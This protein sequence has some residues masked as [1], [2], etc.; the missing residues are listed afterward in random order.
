MKGLSRHLR[1]RLAEGV[2]LRYELASPVARVLALAVDGCAVSAI[3][4][5]LYGLLHPV[6]T[7]RPDWGTAML[8]IGYF[9]VS[10]FYAILLEW[11][12]GGRTLGKRL[13]GL[14]VLDLE[15]RPLRFDQA[16][17]RNLLKLIDRLPL[18]YGLGGIAAVLSPRWQRLGD[19]A[20]GTVV[21]RQRRSALPDWSLVAPE[22]FNSLRSQHRLA[23]RLRQRCSASEAELGLELLQ[24]RAKL[25]D[26]PRLKLFAALAA[27]YRAHAGVLPEALEG[28]SD[29]QWVRAVVD[30]L[31]QAA[32]EER[33]GGNGRRAAAIAQQTPAGV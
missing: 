8:L 6:L 16:L 13:L 21:V 4:G 24:R 32:Q 14:R 19:L 20:A 15:G 18:F 3:L 10:T 5:T 27:R 33:S 29:E 25:E 9:T 1:L 11:L 30:V 23:G 7:A 31:Y 26:G 17:L 2:D 28:L 12:D 22:R